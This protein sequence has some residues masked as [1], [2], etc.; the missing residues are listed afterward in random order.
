MCLILAKAAILDH[1]LRV[2][3]RNKSQTRLLLKR[4]LI[5]LLIVQGAEETLVSL[6]SCQPREDEVIVRLNGVCFEQRP[7]WFTGFTLNL[8]FD[9]VLFFQP[10]LALWERRSRPLVEKIGPLLSLLGASL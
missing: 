3:D 7:M 9:V 5:A 4:M 6:F 8:I 2:L 1:Y 10:I